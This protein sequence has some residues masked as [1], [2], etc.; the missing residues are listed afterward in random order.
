MQLAAGYGITAVEGEGSEG[1]VKIIYT[2]LKR[3][4]LPVVI[5]IFHRMLPGAFLS[6]EEVRSTEQ[7]VFPTAK[8][9]FTRKLSLKK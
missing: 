3:Q 9:Q 2:T 5:D 4:D 7:G 1:T 8:N 6:V